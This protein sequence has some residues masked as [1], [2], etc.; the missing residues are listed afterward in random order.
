MIV[1]IFNAISGIFL[2][3]YLIPTPPYCWLYSVWELPNSMCWECWTITFWHGVFML[4]YCITASII[5]SYISHKIPQLRE[6]IESVT[7]DN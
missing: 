5:F 3:E 2:A 6:F 7:G 1:A 4:A